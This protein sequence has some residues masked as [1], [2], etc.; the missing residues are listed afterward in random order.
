MRLAVSG[1][2]GTG[3]S[4]L[5]ASLAEAHPQYVCEPEAFETLGDDIDLAESGAPTPAALAALIEYTAR[6]VAA[7]PPGAKVIHE[8]SPVDYLAYAAASRREWGR[9]EV[10]RFLAA[11]VPVVRGSLEHLDIIAL[12]P[13][14]AEGP[15]A[16]PGEDP[17]FRRRVDEALRRALVDDD[18]GLFD[19]ASTRVID[20]PRAPDRQLAEL[21]RLIGD[22]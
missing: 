18:H 3:K 9:D 19:G 13:V 11:H 2:P 14:S 8:R 15:P 5:I 16:R 22:A 21:V 10:A 20:L 12:V 6:S 7:H 1:S 4:T 17:R